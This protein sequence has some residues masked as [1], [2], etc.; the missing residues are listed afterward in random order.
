MPFTGP[1]LARALQMNKLIC[2]LDKMQYALWTDILM[3]FSC[4]ENLAMKATAAC[5]KSYF[6]EE[7]G[8]VGFFPL[9]LLYFIVEL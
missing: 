2:S 9:S 3:V 5:G 8:W 4:P 1:A 7:Y 6:K